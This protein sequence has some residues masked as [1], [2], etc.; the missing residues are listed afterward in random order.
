MDMIKFEIPHLN[1]H[2]TVTIV[3][4]HSAFVSQAAIS[5]DFYQNRLLV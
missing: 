5:P 1:M 2:T 3:S 4:L